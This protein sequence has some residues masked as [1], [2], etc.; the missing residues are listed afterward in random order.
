[1]VLITLKTNKE[2][3]AE[4]LE[5]H[6]SIEFDITQTEVVLKDG[7]TRKMFIGKDSIKYFK[8]VVPEGK[9]ELLINLYTNDDADI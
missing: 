7:I 3:T 6:P 4:D 1:M 5:Y 9:K 2:L 8:F